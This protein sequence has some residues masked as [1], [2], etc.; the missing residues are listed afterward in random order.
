MFRA[1]SFFFHFHAEAGGG[2]NG[3]LYLYLEI[4]P[5]ETTHSPIPRDYLKEILRD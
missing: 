4:P 2:E 3:A 5:P 1:L